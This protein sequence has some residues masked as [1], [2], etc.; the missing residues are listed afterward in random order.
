MHLSKKTIS[1]KVVTTAASAALLTTGMGL[2]AVQSAPSAH[3]AGCSNKIFLVDGYNSGM[4]AKSFGGKALTNVTS[5]P[6]WD[7]EIFFYENGIIPVVDPLT[8]N[9]T[10]SKAVPS[11]EHK[12]VAY[13]QACPN[14]KIAFMGYSFGALVAGN[15]VESLAHKNVIPHDQMNAV[16]Y[17][18]P[19][20]A[21][22]AKGVEGMAGGVLTMLPNLPTADAPGPRDFKDVDV[23]EVCNQN[24]VICNAANPFTNAMAVGNEIQGY[25]SGDH[26]YGKFDPF[27]ADSHP[28]DH[29]HAQQPRTNYGP[30]LPLPIPTPNALLNNNPAWNAA[31]KAIGDAIDNATL[32]QLL[33]QFGI[34]AQLSDV[35]MGLVQE[36]GVES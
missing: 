32:A 1:R 27:G 5:A 12:A 20:R 36:A 4:S 6:G 26:G 17:G 14:A 30:P 24:D 8:L 21:P 3:A 16:L 35:A 23:S 9:E 13:H 11:L 31:V 10:V 19:R 29:W 25:L 18:D 15:V 22:H 28:G 33:K 2:A 7:R 34:P